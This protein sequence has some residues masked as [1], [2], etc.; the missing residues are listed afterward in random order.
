MVT[1]ATS[2]HSHA[3]MAVSAHI[4]YTHSRHYTSLSRTNRKRSRTLNLFA[5]ELALIAKP[6][7]CA[8]TRYIQYITLVFEIEGAGCRG[9]AATLLIAQ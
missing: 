2:L 1:R 5:H 4:K 6:R 8:P 3:P 9:G 7:S